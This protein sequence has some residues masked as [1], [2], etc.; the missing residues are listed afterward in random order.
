MRNRKQIKADRLWK[1]WLY[2]LPEQCFGPDLKEIENYD[3]EKYRKA[4]EHFQT[5][6]RKGLT[7]EEIYHIHP[8]IEAQKRKEITLSS[9]AEESMEWWSNLKG[10]IYPWLHT[11]ENKGTMD[12]L[13]FIAI[14][15][16]IKSIAKDPHDFFLRHP[17]ISQQTKHR[18][19]TQRVQN[20]C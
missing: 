16:T 5:K 8:L 15:R 13:T 19:F 10:W 12:R 6:G 1:H 4:F 14:L 7:E 17:G 18:Y 20:L 9:L 11:I 2:W 3:P